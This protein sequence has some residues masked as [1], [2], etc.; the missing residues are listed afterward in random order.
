MNEAYAHHVW[1]LVPAWGHHA[2][3][4]ATICDTLGLNPNLQVT[5]I[6]HAMLS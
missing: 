5:L 6:H 1:W 3:A 4:H 2:A